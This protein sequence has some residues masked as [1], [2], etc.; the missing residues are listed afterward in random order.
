MRL[1]APLLPLPSPYN[2][3]SSGA[4][5]LTQGKNRTSF[6]KEISVQW[7]CIWEALAFQLGGVFVTST[8]ILNLAVSSVMR[9]SDSII[10]LHKN[11]KKQKSHVLWV[12]DMLL[13]F[14]YSW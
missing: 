6:P 2:V 4:A 7:Y 1:A 5:G 11:K 8:S 13:G 12:A 10:F 9:M 3:L 14:S